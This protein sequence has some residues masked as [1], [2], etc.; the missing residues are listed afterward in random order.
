VIPNIDVRLGTR[1][2]DGRGKSHVE[3]LT[4]EDLTG[5]QEEVPAAAVF[6]LIGAEPHTEW[7]HG[8][9]AL[10]KRGFVLTGRDIPQQVWPA[11]RAALPFE[12]S[13]PG[14]FA[15]GDVRF[16]SVK[17]VAG[18]VGEGS[19]TVGFVHQYLADATAW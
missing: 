13:V 7:L 9:V 18:A 12:T 1:V 19:V 10:D 16:G 3:A 2:L 15:A 5:R 6:V 14:V 4:L 17:R 8:L 11:R